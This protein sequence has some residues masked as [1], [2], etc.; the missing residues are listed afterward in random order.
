MRLTTTRAAMPLALAGLLLA[1]TTLVAHA[2]NG[3]GGADGAHRG[4]RTQQV[5]VRP[6]DASGHARP[7]W[8]V[9]RMKGVKADCD[10]SAGAAVTDGIYAC[11]PSAAYLP[12][13]WPSSHHTVLCLRDPRV[14]KLVR[15]RY[16]DTLGTASAP[17]RP[18][19]Q[20]LDLARGQT[21]SVRVG[22]A[23]GT[24]PTHP[25]WVGFYSCTHG[26][27]YGPPDGDGVQRGAQPW[28][29]RVWK[30]GT[31]HDVVHRSVTTA[32]FVGTHR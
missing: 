28:R 10:G 18:T 6:V 19:P 29:V 1:G 16:R 26:S 24:L 4:S 7:G 21:C 12:S 30:S 3:S 14:H 15:V 2:A 8:T 22:G 27:V 25:R 5:V 23:W 31:R 11:F 9:H 13:C 20:G 32:Y 17:D